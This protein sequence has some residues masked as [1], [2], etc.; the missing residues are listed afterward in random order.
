M[1][2][3][4]PATVAG[5]SGNGMV[6][7]GRGHLVLRACPNCQTRRSE[8]ICDDYFGL[9]CRKCDQFFKLE[10]FSGQR[11]ELIQRLAQQGDKRCS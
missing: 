5:L 11:E 7:A 9:Y 3:L 4:P 10:D 8:M 1:L 2:K 6:R